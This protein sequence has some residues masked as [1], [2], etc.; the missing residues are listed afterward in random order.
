MANRHLSRSI[1]MQTLFEW[2]FNGYDD[3]KINGMLERNKKEFGPGVEEDDDF[4]D[5]LVGGVLKKRKKIDGI[6]EKAAPEWPI[7]QVARVDRNVLRLGL[8]ELLF[9]DR[10]EVPPKVAIN[11]SIE[12]A[13]NFG[14]ESSSRFVNGVLGT[15]YK[16]IG[17]P[18]KDDTGKK[19]F[20]GDLSKL[21]IDHLGGGVVYRRIGGGLVFAMVHDVFG[22]WTLSKGKLEKEEK[23]VEKGTARKISEELGISDVRMG[24]NLGMNEYVASD[25]ERGKVRKQVTYFLIETKDEDLQLKESGGLDNIR[26]FEPREFEDMKT[27]PDIKPLLEKAMKILLK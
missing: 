7:E 15:V 24:E 20:E 4:A 11:E 13:K 16:E 3:K 6:I 2:D 18:G 22:Y 26:W 19:P 23:D 27:Y 9:G 21:P 5:R 8:W 25:P 17:E 12:L 1:A 10:D 14:G